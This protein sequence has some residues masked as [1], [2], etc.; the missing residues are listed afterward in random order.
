MRVL[1]DTH[2]WLW[3]AMDPD[4]LR[5]ESRDLMVDPDNQVLLSVAST[6]EIAI[7]YRLGKL[8]L[9]R[10]PAYFLPDL[11][12]RMRIE[13]LPIESRHALRVAELP[14]HHRDPFDRLLVAQAMVEGLPVVSADPQVARYDV[15]VIP[16]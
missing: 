13:D 7:K 16:A 4:R 3:M 10:P 12:A 9:P 8:S 1:L 5:A 2:A 6:W 14:D 15:T 11:M